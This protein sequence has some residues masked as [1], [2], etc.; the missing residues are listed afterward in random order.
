M[1][2]WWE[3]CLVTTLVCSCPV[4]DCSQLHTPPPAAPRTNSD[5]I[6]CLHSK[7][8][9]CSTPRNT[10]KLHFYF[11]VHINKIIFLTLF[12]RFLLLLQTQIQ[13]QTPQNLLPPKILLNRKVSGYSSD[14]K[15][16]NVLD[17][18]HKGSFQKTSL[19]FWEICR[20]LTNTNPDPDPWKHAPTKNLIE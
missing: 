6:I 15:M 5:A 11:F 3:L 7:V 4:V 2:G 17:F 19:L 9:E 8:A 18:L 10:L 16:K 14:T 12:W 20:I 13:I 1:G